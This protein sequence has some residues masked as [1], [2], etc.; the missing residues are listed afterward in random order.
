[1]AK[2]PLISVSI[3]SH[4]QGDMVLRLLK[5]IRSFEPTVD[6]DI[7]LTEN[8]IEASGFFA[9][10]DD[11]TLTKIVND[12][13]KS[14]A[15]NHNLAFKNANG[16]FFCILNPDVVFIESVLEKL[17]AN[18]EENLGDIVAPL[19]INSMNEIQD[20]FRALPSPR[21]MI[22][23]LIRPS[24]HRPSPLSDKPVYPDWLAGI[25]LFMKSE[26]Y[27]NLNGFDEHYKMYFEDVDFCSRAK[28]AG[29]RILFEPRCKIVHNAQRS[30]HK[31][32]LSAF[33]HL[34]SAMRF[35]RSNVY[36]QIRNRS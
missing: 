2:Q 21:I 7:I 6:L 33:R 16:E 14:F 35:F 30:S 25:L 1:M 10:I 24:K 17:V 28:L 31:D 29:F 23:R 27:S 3:V 9:E 8:L 22:D 26:T 18:I 11:Q 15:A 20:S 32:P 13:A 5:S 4:G 12:E 34:S 19:V 36:R